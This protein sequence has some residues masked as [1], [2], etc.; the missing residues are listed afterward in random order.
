[1]IYHTSTQ[2]AL[3]KFKLLLTHKEN[4]CT[5]RMNLLFTL[6]KI[7][8]YSKFLQSIIPGKQQKCEAKY[9]VPFNKVSSRN[10]NIQAR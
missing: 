8:S 4:S 9:F 6:C 10:N 7:Q 3:F 1:M 5:Q 2:K